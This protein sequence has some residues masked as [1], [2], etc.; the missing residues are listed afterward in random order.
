MLPILIC[1][2]TRSQLVLVHEV[3]REEKQHHA[4]ITLHRSCVLLLWQMCCMCVPPSALK[5]PYLC[6][7]CVL[8]CQMVAWFCCHQESCSRGIDPSSSGLGNVFWSSI[9]SKT[10][11][12]SASSPCVS[13]SPIVVFNT[14][15]S[16]Q[17][18]IAQFAVGYHRAIINSRAPLALIPSQAQ[19]PQ[20]HLVVQ[21]H[22]L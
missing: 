17:Y 7:F 5:R 11:T 4:C 15:V 1:I 14:D 2:H 22:L 10:L 3:L 19:Q 20:C 9:F 6:V 16:A 8:L 12:S 13:L 21:E 18:I